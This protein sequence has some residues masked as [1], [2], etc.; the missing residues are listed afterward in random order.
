M[1]NT[2]IEKMPVCYVSLNKVLFFCSALVTIIFSL[3]PFWVLSIS[4]EEFF[5]FFSYIVLIDHIYV[6]SFSSSM[7]LYTRQ[8]ERER[9]LMDIDYK[10]E[11]IRIKFIST[12]PSTSVWQ[13][14]HLNYV[15]F[16]RQWTH[17]MFVCLSILNDGRSK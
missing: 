13:F 17:D 2:F 6:T 8:N 12:Q 11:F 9:E 10:T 7:I 15:S 4:L 1:H 3:L 5:L 16:S 14:A